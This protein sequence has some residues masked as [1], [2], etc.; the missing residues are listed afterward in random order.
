MPEISLDTVCY[1]IIK[2][3]EF[4]AKVDVEEPD[5]GSN[6]A[7]DDMAGVLQDY[8]DDPTYAELKEAIEDLNLDEQ[9]NLVALT[10]LGRGDYTKEDWDEALAEATRAH[11]KRTAE[12]LMGIP[13][14]GDFLEEGLAAFDLSCEE[15]EKNHL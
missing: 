4:D 13:L 8:A 7:D 12:Y 9:V 1:I 14:L 3:R 6:A 5:A 11:N 10:W 15:I 2:A